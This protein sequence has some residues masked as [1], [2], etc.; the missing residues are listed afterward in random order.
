MYSARWPS[1]SFAAWYASWSQLLPG[2]TTM[3]NFIG[4]SPR[5]VS[6]DSVHFDSIAFNHRVREELVGN[7]RGERPRL[8]GFRRRQIQLEVLPLPHVLDAGVAE[9]MERVGNRSSLRIEHGWLQ[10]DEDART[11]QA[12]C[13]I[14][15]P[16][17]SAWK[18]RSKM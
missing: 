17:G 8:R 2:K 5:R 13:L 15:G 7:L 6:K 16:A 18:T 11:H 12:L 3:P 10:C 1:T 9:R 14:A 4:D